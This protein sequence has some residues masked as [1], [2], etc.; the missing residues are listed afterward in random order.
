MGGGGGCLGVRRG[1]V[2]KP[3]SCGTYWPAVLM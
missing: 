1:A 3:K 2:D